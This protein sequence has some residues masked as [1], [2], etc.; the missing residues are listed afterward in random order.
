METDEDTFP[1]LSSSVRPKRK[2][3]VSFWH[4]LP[5]AIG[6]QD[7]KNNK[8]TLFVSSSLPADLRD[9]RDRGVFF[10]TQVGPRN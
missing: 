4:Q 3:S 2:E 1:G 10:D 9:P 8:P 7:S 6:R 5:V